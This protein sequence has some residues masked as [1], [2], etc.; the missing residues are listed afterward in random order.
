MSTEDTRRASD[1]F[2][3]FKTIIGTAYL[4]TEGRRLISVQLSSPRHACWTDQQP[5]KTW[6]CGICVA[7]SWV[8]A[9]NNFNSLLVLQFFALWIGL[10]VGSG[11]VQR[12]A[13][14]DGSGQVTAFVGRVGS[15][16]VDPRA[17]LAQSIDQAVFEPQSRTLDVCENTISI[18]VPS[19]SHWSIP[20]PVY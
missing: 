13:W 3:G 9:H 17:T 1:S 12:A 19:H 10:R 6:A 15:G 2:I 5:V 16:N 14:T 8:C 18:P 11:R 7:H 20:I 4:E